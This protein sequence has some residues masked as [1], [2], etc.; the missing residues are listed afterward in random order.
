MQ[1]SEL[2]TIKGG[3][4]LGYKGLGHKY[5]LIACPRCEK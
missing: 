4:E 1:I 3:T 2:G 5:I